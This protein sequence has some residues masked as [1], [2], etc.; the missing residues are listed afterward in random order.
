MAQ[1]TITIPNAK[2]NWVM[3]AVVPPDDPGVS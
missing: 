3:D 2:A 1:I